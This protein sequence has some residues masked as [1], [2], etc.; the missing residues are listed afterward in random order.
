MTLSAYL[1]I[2]RRWWWALLLAP[3]LGGAAAFGVSSQMTPIYEA[4]ATLLVVQRQD[5]G[6]IQLNDLQ[7]S[8]RLAATFS[9]LIGLDPVLEEA[10]AAL[11]FPITTKEI[12][13]RLTVSNPRATQLL[14]VN[15]EHP[16]PERARDIANL[17]SEVFIAQNDS[18]FGSRPGAVTVVE[19]AKI[20][21][22]PVS[23]RTVLNVALG[24][25]AS[26]MVA[27]GVIALFEYL[28]DTVKTADDVAEVTG[29]STLGLVPRFRKVEQRSEQL[30]ISIE[31]RSAVAESY[32][33]VRTAIEY[34]IPEQTRGVVLL[35]TSAV[36]SEGKTTVSANL[37]VAFALEGK[38]VLLIDAD[39]RKPTLH[40]LFAVPNSY[41]LSTA[42]TDESGTGKFSTQITAHPNL[43]ILPAGPIVHS[44]AELLGSRR[45]ALSLD[46]ARDQFDLIICDTPPVLSATD[47]S[48]LARSVDASLFV[49]RA[50]STRRGSL[51]E[52]VRLIAQAGRPVLGV[53]VNR[54]SGSRAGYA[55]DSYYGEDDE[56]WEEEQVS[57]RITPRPDALPAQEAATRLEPESPLPPTWTLPVQG[58]DSA[59]STDSPQAR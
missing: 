37:A 4:T 50:G 36:P 27:I 2:V 19:R 26:L 8:E 38:R 3:I 18:E 6:V 53:I 41:G 46:A 13:E 58:Q 44:V 51:E 47:S 24:V 30:R 17:V 21:E 33:A 7:A 11:P 32:R 25:M 12:E 5:E 49:A 34:A 29:L 28:D 42:L 23:P 35:V 48:V 15:V 56:R 20:P 1:V 52:S 39:L 59:E 22:S 31:P 10:S 45:M 54:V 57:E 43:R 16:D 14:R 40:D 9:Q 55:Y